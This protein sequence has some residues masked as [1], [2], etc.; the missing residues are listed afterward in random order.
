MRIGG[1]PVM[2]LVPTGLFAIFALLVVLSPTPPG[3]WFDRLLHLFG[4]GAVSAR[5]AALTLWISSAVA[6]A[7]AGSLISR[8]THIEP[9]LVV[10]DAAALGLACGLVLIWLASRRNARGSDVGD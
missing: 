3:R 9:V 5:A 6:S 7:I 2:W 10:V 4:I 1:R 8:Y